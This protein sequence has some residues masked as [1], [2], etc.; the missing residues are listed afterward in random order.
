LKEIGLYS[1]DDH[2][3]PI[4]KDNHAMDEFRYSVNAFYKKYANF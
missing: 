2:G 3:K 1:R 4:D